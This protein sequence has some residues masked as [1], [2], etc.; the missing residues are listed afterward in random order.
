[1]KQKNALSVPYFRVEL[2]EDEIGEVSEVLRS[3]WLTTGPCVA[4]FEKEFEIAVGAI[5]KDLLNLGCGHPILDVDVHPL[6]LDGQRRQRS[7]LG[8]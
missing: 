3:G 5:A 7:I 8:E 6:M 2:G 4:D 1:M